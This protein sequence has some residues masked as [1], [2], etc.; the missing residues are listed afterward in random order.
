M[1]R[2]NSAVA[3]RRVSRAVE[4][5]E[6]W[7]GSSRVQGARAGARGTKSGF[8]LND[9]VPPAC[10]GESFGREPDSARHRRAGDRHAALSAEPVCASAP[11]SSAESARAWGSPTSSSRTIPR[12]CAMSPTASRRWRE[13]RGD[14]QRRA[15]L[16]GRAAPVHA[17]AARGDADHPPDSSVVAHGASRSIEPP[18]AQTAMGRGFRDKER[19]A[20]PVSHRERTGR[21]PCCRRARA[22]RWHLPDGRRRSVLR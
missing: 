3:I 18:E 2:S 17:G 14:G 12:S 11:A 4:L 22:S 21:I 5:L 13:D 10:G 8:R 9:S 16:R 15:D 20:G 7:R 6:G 19:S 1:R